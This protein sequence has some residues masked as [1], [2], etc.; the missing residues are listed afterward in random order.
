MVL[1]MKGRAGGAEK[2]QLLLLRHL[3]RHSLVSLFMFML[4]SVRSLREC[5][6]SS[7]P[8]ASVLEECALLMSS[9]KNHEPLPR[10]CEH[11]CPLKFLP[12]LGVI[13]WP[14]TM[15]PI[16]SSLSEAQICR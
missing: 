10:C 16:T 11:V 15:L 4:Q 6:S 2:P 9:H 1:E 5:F 14:V 3:A 12:Q 8:I 13:S 7:S